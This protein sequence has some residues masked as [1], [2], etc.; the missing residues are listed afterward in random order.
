MIAG[1]RERAEGL[2]QQI[3]KMQSE[4]DTA[5]AS[6]TISARDL[7]AFKVRY[8]QIAHDEA[9]LAAA[10]DMSKKNFVEEKARLLHHIL[11]LHDT[12]ERLDATPHPW[13]AEPTPEPTTEELE[14]EQ[15]ELDDHRYDSTS[16]SDSDETDIE[17]WGDEVSNDDSSDSEEGTELLQEGDLPLEDAASCID[18]MP[19]GSSCDII[20]KCAGFAG[21][22]SFYCGNYKGEGKVSIISCLF[23][24]STMTPF[25]F[26]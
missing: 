15:P 12:I 3:T 21:P 2:V 5:R 19:K 9:D 14:Q 10:F 8:A 13:E 16:E 4:I 7:A 6:A 11:V 1:L 17:F 22:F 20:N 25:F 23:L 18:L 26:R 24:A